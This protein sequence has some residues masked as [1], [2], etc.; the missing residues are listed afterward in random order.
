MKIKALTKLDRPREKLIRYGSKRLSTPELLAVVLGFGQKGENV[1]ELSRKILKRFPKQT[2]SEVKFKELT[3]IAG[4]GEV[5]ACQIIA[6]LE[7]GRRLLKDNNSI[8]ILS[9]K[10][11]WEELRD[12]RDNKKEHFVAFYLDVK[13]QIIAKE[14]ISVGTLNASLVHPR[15]VF[16]PAIK[17]LAAQIILAHN[18]P[19]GQSTASEEDIKLTRRLISAGSILGI[20]ITDHVIVCKDGYSSMRQEGLIGVE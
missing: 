11:I 14:M 20:E 17:S 3:E 16:E 15:E 13:N 1:V 12:I 4:I 9:P 7:F 6:C 19:S 10:E 5:K 18:H 2:L 8:L